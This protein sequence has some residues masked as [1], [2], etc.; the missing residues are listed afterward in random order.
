MI[1]SI[2]VLTAGP[3]ALRAASMCSAVSQIAEVSDDRAPVSGLRRVCILKGGELRPLGQRLVL[4]VRGF[5][6]DGVHVDPPFVSLQRYALLC[7][8]PCRWTNFQPPSS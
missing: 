7:G 6:N 8:S 2:S 1:G 3:M 4:R 5:A